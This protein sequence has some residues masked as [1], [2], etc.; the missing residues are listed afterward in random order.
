LRGI[1]SNKNH[2]LNIPDSDNCS[3]DAQ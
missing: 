2:A 1:L 3:S